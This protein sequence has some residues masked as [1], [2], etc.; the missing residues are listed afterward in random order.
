M[1]QKRDE[2]DEDD[3][4][5]RYYFDQARKH[6]ERYNDAFDWPAVEVTLNMA[7]TYDVC[8]QRLAKTFSEKGLSFAAFNVLSILSRREDH[9]C[10]QKDLSTLL[11]V[12]RANITEVVDTL[13]R[14]GYVSRRSCEKDRR[15]CIVTITEQGMAAVAA[16]FP[17]HFALLKKITSGLSV[18]EKDALSRLLT[19]LRNGVFALRREE[20]SVPCTKKS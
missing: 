20:G 10:S 15:V 11:L 19:K 2:Y 9:S 4:R 17:T 3:I 5:A 1:A 13:I 18:A 7:N 16:L 8:L 12:S 6:G 14:K